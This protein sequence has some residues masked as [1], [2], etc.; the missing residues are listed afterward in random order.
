[1]CAPRLGLAQKSVEPGLLV[2]AEKHRTADEEIPER[3]VKRLKTGS[4]SDGTDETF[5][6]TIEVLNG[7]PVLCVKLHAVDAEK[8]PCGALDLNTE[9]HGGCET[10]EDEKGEEKG[11]NLA[12]M[13]GWW[14]RSFGTPA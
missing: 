10:M 3:P 7:V 12:G 5:C 13:I 11:E 8:E 1:M 4:E 9:F 14:I 2:K 6:E